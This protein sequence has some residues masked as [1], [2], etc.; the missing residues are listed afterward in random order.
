[1]QEF[2]TYTFHDKEAIGEMAKSDD[3]SALNDLFI[4]IHIPELVLQPELTE[5]LEDFQMPR[6]L[7]LSRFLKVDPIDGRSRS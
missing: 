6:Y 2:R 7:N 1:M 4:L 3:P 5:I